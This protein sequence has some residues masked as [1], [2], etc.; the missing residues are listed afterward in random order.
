MPSRVSR[1]T[2][3][4]LLSRGKDYAEIGK[5][6][7]V[8]R[9]MVRRRVNEEG[10]C[11]VCV[12]CHKPNRARGKYCASCKAEKAQVDV[13]RW[14]RYK[15]K[16]FA[17]RPVVMEA[18]RFFAELGLDVV[19]NAEC[20]RCEPELYVNGQG[21]KCNRMVPV[22]AGHQVRFCEVRDAQWWYLGDG[23][24]ALV[25]NAV[26]A[27]PKITYIGASHDL[28]RYSVEEWSLEGLREVL[29]SG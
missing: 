8:S 15:L 7:G 13:K 9:E 5:V 11:K 23:E 29:S 2:L 10:L 25:V 17:Y 6:I 18:Y 12:V 24:C 28:R 3:Q 19:V 16:T 21:V 27:D 20:L 4:A 22:S 26:D 1:E 14:R